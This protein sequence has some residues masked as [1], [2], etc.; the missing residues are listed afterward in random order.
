MSE[1]KIEAIKIENHDAGNT[2]DGKIISVKTLEGA[3][4]YISPDIKEIH[5]DT[6]DNINVCRGHVNRFIRKNKGLLAK[7]VIFYSHGKIYNPNRILT[8][9]EFEFTRRTIVTNPQPARFNSYEPIKI[10]AA[11]KEHINRVKER[12]E[13]L[14]KGITRK[15]KQGILKLGKVHIEFGDRREYELISDGYEY[16]LIINKRRIV[17][18]MPLEFLILFKGAS[19]VSFNPS[20]MVRW[21][22]NIDPS[23]MRLY[24]ERSVVATLNRLKD[25]YGIWFVRN[26]WYYELNTKM[27]AIIR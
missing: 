4:Y 12:R 9:A 7:D 5:F 26:D 24:N 27:G 13:I 3:S 25:K 18:L 22:K 2:V 8:V 23:N 1:F 17:D 21:I 6:L 20:D 14:Q 15:T 11:K 16:S 10:P 19:G